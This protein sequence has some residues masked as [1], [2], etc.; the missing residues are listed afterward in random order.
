MS[1]GKLFNIS[2]FELKMSCQRRMCEFLEYAID[3]ELLTSCV[4]HVFPKHT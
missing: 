3:R 1:A 4:S 2:D